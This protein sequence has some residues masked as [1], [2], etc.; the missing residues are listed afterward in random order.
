MNGI[1][2]KIMILLENKI[3]KVLNLEDNKEKN[4]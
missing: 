4:E 2:L 3:N 1:E